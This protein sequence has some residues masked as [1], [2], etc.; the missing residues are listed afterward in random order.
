VTTTSQSL[1]LLA[2]LARVLLPAENAK[3][4]RRHGK[5]GK[6]GKTLSSGKTGK[7]GKTLSSGKTGKS[8]NEAAIAVRRC[9]ELGSPDAPETRH[10][11]ARWCCP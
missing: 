2:A 9:D 7:S 1:P 3:P 6:S 8:G 11:N 5:T 4:I 10:Q